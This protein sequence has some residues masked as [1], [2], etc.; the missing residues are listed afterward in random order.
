MRETPARAIC[1]KH[2]WRVAAASL[3]STILTFLVG[4]QGF[5][6]AKTSQQQ[7]QIGTLSLNSTN[8]DFGTVIAGASKTLTVTASNTGS[9]SIT[10]SSASISSQYFSLRAPTLPTAV[11]A[12]Q[13]VPITLVFTPNAA[14]SFSGTVSVASNATNNPAMFALAGTGVAPSGQ[15]ALS[16][17]TENFGNVM[18]GSNQSL[19]ETVT[20]TG[21]ASVTISQVGIS[22]TGFTL[23]GIST[24]MTLTAGQS[25]NFSVTF[26]P[27]SSGSDSGNLTLASNASTPTLTV[28]LSGTGVTPG[29]LGSNPANLSFGSVI[30]G[31]KQTLSETL[32]NTGGSSVTISQVAI[33][34]AGFS[35]GG[36]AAPVTLTA[37]QSITFT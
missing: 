15:L 16:S 25:A 6:S 24:P 14:G 36:I 32:T 37:G 13:S 22:G 8:V 12:G 27:P 31:G 18:V 19:S 30:V 17:A 26:A 29:M 33:N 10:V 3:L 23:S 5:S 21:N 35:L 20:N 9:A 7:L 1:S 34:G 4:C 28:P 11:L 2:L